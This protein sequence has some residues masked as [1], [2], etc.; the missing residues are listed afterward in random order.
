M[1]Y[2]NSAP[3]TKLNKIQIVNDLFRQATSPKTRIETILLVVNNE[4]PGSANWAN[5]KKESSAVTA[6]EA[7]KNHETQFREIPF[8]ILFSK[9]YS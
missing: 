7:T 1:S 3:A 5:F 8:F 9:V 2:P 4:L 6:K